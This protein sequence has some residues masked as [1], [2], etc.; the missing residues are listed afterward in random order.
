MKINWKHV[1]ISFLIGALAGAACGL[2]SA[3]CAYRK[4]SHGKSY[5]WILKRFSRKLDLT[6]DQKEK[7]AAVLKDKRDKIKELRAEI[8]PRFKALHDSTGEDIRKHLDPEQRQKFDAMRAKWEA[9]RKERREKQ[10]KD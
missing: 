9:R 8:R 4:H 6:D 7:V 10:E 2:W 5:E 1:A 3:R